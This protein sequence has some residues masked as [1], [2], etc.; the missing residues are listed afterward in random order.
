MTDFLNFFFA[1][2]GVLV[3]GFLIHIFYTMRR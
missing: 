1:F 3:V 2:L